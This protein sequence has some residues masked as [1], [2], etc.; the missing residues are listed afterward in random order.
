M[1]PVFCILLAWALPAFVLW[2]SGKGKPPR[3]PYLYP[4]GSFTACAAGM[5]L[6]LYTIR[7]RANAGDF[8]GIQDTI[9]GVLLLCILLLGGTVILNLIASAASFP[10]A[11]SSPDVPKP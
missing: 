5:I 7:D 11:P 3:L 8:G 10:D 1:I 2:R 4:I 6:E 9:D